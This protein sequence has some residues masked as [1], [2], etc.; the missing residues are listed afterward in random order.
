MMSYA[1]V[2]FASGSFLRKGQG[3]YQRMQGGTLIL[4][5]KYCQKGQCNARLSCTLNVM[6]VEAVTSSTAAAKY[7]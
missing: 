7:P 3:N 4:L 5:I 6:E 2:N 1:L